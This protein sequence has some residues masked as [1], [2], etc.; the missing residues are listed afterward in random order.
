[1]TTLNSRDAAQ[2]VRRWSPKAHVLPQ[3]VL[4]FHLYLGG[5]A[6]SESFPTHC[7]RHLPACSLLPRHGLLEFPGCWTSYF[8]FQDGW[9]QAGDRESGLWGGDQEEAAHWS[10]A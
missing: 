9:Q 5:A 6:R 3:F 4:G 10:S 7:S 1:M 2:A 8:A